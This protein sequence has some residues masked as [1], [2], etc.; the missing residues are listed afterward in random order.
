M[1][2]VINLG[3]ASTAPLDPSRP[4]T[5]E[6]ATRLRELSAY[7]REALG[8]IERELCDGKSDMDT[9]LEAIVEQ[10]RVTGDRAVREGRAFR[11][12]F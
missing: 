9:D 4:A 8:L 10:L 1:A 12:P 5:G 6:Y 2:D 11:C 3:R 7:C